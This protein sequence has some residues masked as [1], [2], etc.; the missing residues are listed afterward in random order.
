[1]MVK[2]SISLLAVVTIVTS[3]VF[4]EEVTCILSTWSICCIRMLL[5]ILVPVKNTCILSLV[6]GGL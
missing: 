2:V 1:M 4:L 6:K 3:D 5:K